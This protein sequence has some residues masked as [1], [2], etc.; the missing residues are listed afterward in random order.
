MKADWIKNIKLPKIANKHP[1]AFW[2]AIALHLALVVGL[3]FSSVQRWEIPKTTPKSSKAVPKAVTVDLTE[4]KK[5]KQ[6]LINVK[7]KREKRLEDL[8]RA[9][10]RV[11][12]ERYKEQQRLK[13]LKAKTKKEKLAEAQAEKSRKV[14]EQKKK[15]ALKEKRLAEEQ[16][17]KAEARKK[18]A[19]KK[20]KAA[21][22]EKQ[23]IEKLRKVEANKFEKEQD[24]R[25]LKKEI[26]AEEDQEREFAQE[27]ILNELKANYINQIASRVKEQWR[28]QGAKDNWGCDVY[29][30]QDLN[31]K[32]QSVNLQSCNVTN[33]A[34]AKAF[35]DAIERAVYKASPLPPA[36]DKSVYD[37]EILFHFRV[38]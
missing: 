3:V 17:N 25:S 32:V 21:E 19:E 24:T 1:I 16:A 23:K 15:L 9:E 12:N 37:R 34:K 35:K 13:K 10:K 26:Q 38:N 7:Q 30:L 29:I 31:G 28:Y 18:L 36:P 14:A 4:I 22:Q 33:G 20:A 2:T 8:K 6:R 11:E 5:E 27:D